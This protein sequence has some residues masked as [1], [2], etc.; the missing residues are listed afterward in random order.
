[1]GAND[2]KAI[3]GDTRTQ[4]QI[5]PLFDSD[6]DYN[7]FIAAATAENRMFETRFNTIGGSH[8]GERIAEDAGAHTN[9]AAAHGLQATASAFAG[10]PASALMS[11]LRFIGSLTNGTA[12][13]AVR[14]A[15][16]RILT[17]TNPF[18]R[19]QLIAALR[20][21]QERPI[22]TP[23]AVR[24]LA[25][26]IAGAEPQLPAPLRLPFLGGAQPNQQSGP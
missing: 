7:R 13:P 2:S 19:I 10:E 4:R 24:P 23:L 5:R 8:S 16:A 21:M 18:S 14:A 11:G 25:A 20:Q 22:A 9:G 6:D 3:I 15:A 1:M 17:E 12:S 26:A